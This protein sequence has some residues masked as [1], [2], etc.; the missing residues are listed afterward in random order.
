[1]E[2]L[3]VPVLVIRIG[4]GE[5]AASAVSCRLQTFQTVVA[6]G[7]GTGIAVLCPLL[8]GD[9]APTVVGQV[10][11]EQAASLG[12][13]PRADVVGVGSLQHRLAVI[14]H[15]GRASELVVAVA[16]RN[17]EEKNSPWKRDATTARKSS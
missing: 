6:V 14:L 11:S 9:V 3:D 7:I 1:M 15:G 13:Q 12:G 16:G 8:S 5:V 2:R 17:G 10:L 4:G